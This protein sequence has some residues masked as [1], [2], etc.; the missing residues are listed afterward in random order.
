ML[1]PRFI[2]DYHKK[3]YTM[4]PNLDKPNAPETS[5]PSTERGRSP[6]QSWIRFEEEEK[7]E[8]SVATI[9]PTQTIQ[10]HKLFSS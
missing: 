6:V 8:E 7:R 5:N 9:V 4:D 1:N 2:S 3:L 10:V